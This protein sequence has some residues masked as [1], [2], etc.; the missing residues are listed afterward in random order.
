MKS[1]LFG[2]AMA[3]ALASGKVFD[4]IPWYRRIWGGGG[5]PKIIN[6]SRYSPHQGNREKDRRLR[7][8]T[9]GIIQR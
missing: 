2:A 1:K 8:L 6:R 5:S 9:S 7:Q 3:M 4:H